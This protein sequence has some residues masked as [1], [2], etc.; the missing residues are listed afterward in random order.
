MKNEFEK[1]DRFMERHAPTLSLK[2]MSAPLIKNNSWSGQSLV[3]AFGIA[4]LITWGVFERNNS[5]NENALTL[6]QT[7]ATDYTQNEMTE[8]V[9]AEW[10]SYIF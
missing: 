5:Y 10:S 3:L 8:L 4:T 9:E 1:L 6:Y 7:L 2:T